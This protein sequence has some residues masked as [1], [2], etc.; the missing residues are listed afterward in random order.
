MISGLESFRKTVDVAQPGD[1]LGILLRNVPAKTLRRGCVVVPAGT[2]AT[3]NFTDKVKA[4]LY[5]LKKEEG[6]SKVPIA[7]YVHQHIFSLTWDNNAVLK[8]EGK[9]F[10][11]P[12]ENAE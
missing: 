2:D 4:Q 8:I 7:N 6:G 12:G 11:M 10:I 3:K 1:Q 5:V 9:D